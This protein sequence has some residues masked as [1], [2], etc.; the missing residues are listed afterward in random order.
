MKIWAH[1]GCSQLYPENTITSFRK[2]AELFDRGLTG[3]ELDV[4]LTRDGE[5]VVIHDERIDRTTDGY[6]FV[7][8]YSLEELKTFHIHTGSPEAEHIPTLREVMDLI[9][10][11]MRKGFRL[12]IE[13]KNGIYPY[14][15]MEEKVHDLVEQYGLH[16]Q[17]VY[18]SFY[19]RSLEIM[20]NID[21]NVEIGILD[22]RVSDCLFKCKGGCGANA[23]HPAGWGI[24]LPKERLS[25][26]TVRAWF[27]GHL[28]PEKP[29]G[30]KMNL[31]AL[32]EKGVTDVFLNEPE[33]YF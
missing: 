7:R 18:S 17:V 21:P 1:R 12:N 2:A 4:Q 30:G 29:T 15:G 11:P 31:H 32:A 6:G 25:G 33:A 19:A 8:D 28:Y 26:Y 5:I 13:L 20:R 14:P 3:I 16:D 23:L 24:D 22:G 10:A 27:S 9:E